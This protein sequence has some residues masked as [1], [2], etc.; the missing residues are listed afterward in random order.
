MNKF[1]FVCFFIVTSVEQKK[2]NSVKQSKGYPNKGPPSLTFPLHK[3]P[4]TIVSPLT[5]EGCIKS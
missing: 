1:E 2:E 3:S 4:L 5:S